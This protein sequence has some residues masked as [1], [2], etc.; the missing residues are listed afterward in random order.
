MEKEFDSHK[1][2][3]TWSVVPHPGK[4][5]N[6]INSKWIYS[7]KYGI[8]GEEIAKARLVA[9][10]YA[11]SNNYTEESIYAP[12][13]P[14]DI[15]RLIILIA[16]EKNSPLIAL[17]MTTAYLYGSL[18]GNIE[19]EIYMRIPD[20]LNIGK[21]FVLKLLRSIYG[22]RIAS[23]CWYVTLRNSLQEIGYQAFKTE[24]CL[25]ETVMVQFRYW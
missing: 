14:I 25:L 22:L 21:S 15:I 9:V 12:V 4:G 6:I 3:E 17:D 20:G 11:D 13:C 16:Q 7:V 10:G 18:E 24:R 23:K 5:K 1:E 8:D 19:H 2:N